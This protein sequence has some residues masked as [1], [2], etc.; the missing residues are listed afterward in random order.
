[1][2]SDYEVHSD[3]DV[4]FL[5]CGVLCPGHQGPTLLEVQ[6][7]LGSVWLN[8]VRLD[9]VAEY[10]NAGGLGA[11]ERLRVVAKVS[12]LHLPRL[13]SHALRGATDTDVRDAVVE[14]GC[15]RG[16]GIVCWSHWWRKL[17]APVT[18]WVRGAGTVSS[19][20]KA[21]GRHARTRGRVWTTV[22]AEPRFTSGE[23]Q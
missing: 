1:M 19:H 2:P 15:T 5:V 23:R 20:F 3:I 22:I 8:D 16:A 9:N 11:E 4:Q 10:D 13:L 6:S 12:N 7:I 14:R 18:I 21:R 17:R